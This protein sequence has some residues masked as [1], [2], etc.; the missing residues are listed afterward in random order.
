MTQTQY[1]HFI[2]Y[3]AAFYSNMSN[4]HSFGHRKFIPEIECTVFEEI[5]KC[6]PTFN[7]FNYIWDCV[8]EIVYDNSEQSNN[9]NLK[10]KGG[11]NYYYIGDIKEEKIKQIDQFLN[12]NKISP[13]NTRLLKINS[14]QYAY[15]VGS[16]NHKIE[17]WENNNIIGYYSK[18]LY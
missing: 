2:A 18:K 9:I 16:I 17:K 14:N 13:L 15:L 7:E 3:A 11:I 6:S 12:D 10:E 1:K 4:F 5:L 8:K